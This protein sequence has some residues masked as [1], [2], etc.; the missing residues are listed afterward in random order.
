MKRRIPQ[1][2]TNVAGVFAHQ[3]FH[4]WVKSSAC[5]TRGIKEFDDRHGSVH[6]PK[7]RRVGTNQ[8]TCR[9][10]H[11]V[12]LGV[13]DTLLVDVHTERKEGCNDTHENCNG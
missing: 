2:Q 6:R 5:L 7:H 12:H 4:Q 1:H 11:F 13:L 10:A 9:L 3:V 8:P